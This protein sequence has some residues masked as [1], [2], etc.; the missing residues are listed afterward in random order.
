MKL[1]EVYGN[2]GNAL[3]GEW[4]DLSGLQQDTKSAILQLI[5]LDETVDIYSKS[6]CQSEAYRAQTNES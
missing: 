2:D 3:G 6:I 5:F 4:V 1:I